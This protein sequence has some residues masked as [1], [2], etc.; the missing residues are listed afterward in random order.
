MAFL[1][2]QQKNGILVSTGQSFKLAGYNLIYTIW[3]A[4]GKPTD[5]GWH[6]SADDLNNA[7]NEGKKPSETFRFLI[8][9]D[10][11]AHRRIVITELLDIYVY[12]F[13]GTTREESSWSP[14]MLRMRYVMFEEFDDREVSLEEKQM[15]IQGIEDVDHQEDFVE[16]LYMNGS[17]RGWTWGMNGMTNAAFLQG[18][19]REFFRQYF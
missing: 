1:V 19:A 5:Q 2:Y 4:I 14:M 15:M 16:F 13:R 10:P 18:A 7:Y 8:D 11:N 3:T 17:Q 6:I 12:T 9:V